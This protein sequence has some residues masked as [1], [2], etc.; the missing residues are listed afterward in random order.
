MV[1][2]AIGER[3]VWF[4]KGVAVVDEIKQ[5]AGET[6]V[7][8]KPFGW[9]GEPGWIP[10]RASQ[11][12]IRPLVPR[13]IAVEW[14]QELESPTTPPDHGDLF[15]RRER[16]LRTVE[17]G[18]P[19]Q[20]VAALAHL[21]E[22]AHRPDVDDLAVLEALERLVL[23][24]IA[25][26][27]DI[28]VET[29]RATLTARS[30]F[31][32]AAPASG[33]IREK[34]V[35][36][37]LPTGWEHIGAFTIAE[38]LHIGDLEEVAITV[39]AEPGRWHVVNAPREVDGPAESPVI[40]VAEARLGD[41]PLDLHLA[42]LV[43]TN[44]ARRIAFFDEGAQHDKLVLE[45]IW[46]AFAAEVRGRAVAIHWTATKEIRTWTERG[47][48]VAVEARQKPYDK[49]DDSA[50]DEVATNSLVRS[51]LRVIAPHHLTPLMRSELHRAALSNTRSH[52]NPEP[53][54]TLP[55]LTSRVRISSPAPRF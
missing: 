28:P 34:R 21:Y 24:E 27:L 26:S 42:S 40:A 52:W 6:F 14:L 38:A 2:H 4:R 12:H 37:V 10:E 43:A 30:R 8:V 54:I 18:E 11:L 35:V 36:P 53:E 49:D 51:Q 50:R 15:M 39:R 41:L 29:L 3:V 44:D 33:T 45:E 1:W 25:C 9:S 47:R 19:E 16:A 22:E 20:Q 23:L 31:G 17:H 7:I 32:S 48:C 55:R 46:D 13:E 5:S